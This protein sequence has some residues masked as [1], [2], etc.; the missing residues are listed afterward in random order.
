M[1]KIKIFI[2]VIIFSIS[3]YSQSS[4][5]TS[6]KIVKFW[7][8]NGIS[9][10]E[11]VIKNLDKLCNDNKLSKMGVFDLFDNYIDFNKLNN[12]LKPDENG[13]Y[14]NYTAVILGFTT[15]KA[16]ELSFFSSA[17]L[18][19]S[20][21]SDMAAL[22]ILFDILKGNDQKFVNNQIEFYT[23]YVTEGIMDPYSDPDLLDRGYLRASTRSKLFGSWVLPNTELTPDTVKKIVMNSYNRIHGTENDFDYSQQN[24]AVESY[25]QFEKNA[26]SI[27]GYINGYYTDVVLVNVN[28]YHKALTFYNNGVDTLKNMKL[29]K[30][31]DQVISIGTIKPKE[32]RIITSG[33]IQDIDASSFDKI[34][35]DLFGFT[36]SLDY[37]QEIK[38]FGSTVTLKTDITDTHPG[39]APEQVKFQILVNTDNI[40]D[41]P[42]EITIDYG[43]K[44]IETIQTSTHDGLKNISIP[45]TYKQKGIFFPS[46]TVKN[47]NIANVTSTHFDY[48]EVDNPIKIKYPLSINSNYYAGVNSVWNS[49][50][51]SSIESDFV[52]HWDFEYNN[53]NFIRDKDS[54]IANWKFTP[55]AS[56]FTNNRVVESTVAL[57]ASVNIDNTIYSDTLF[58]TVN[59]FNPI[60]P[61][62]NLLPSTKN[63]TID[64]ASIPYQVSLD[65]SASISKTGK[66]LNYRWYINKADSGSTQ[67]VN[68]KILK[69]GKHLIYLYISDGTYNSEIRDS[70]NV[71]YNVKFNSDFSIN[72][73]EYF[74]DNDPGV[75]KGYS[76]PVTYQNSVIFANS[77]ISCRNL[78]T[79]LH[80][81]YF[82]VK[83]NSGRWSIPQS[84]IVI[85]QAFNPSATQV[86]DAE[87]FFD[88]DPG[89]GNG[90]KMNVPT[91]NNI[92]TSTLCNLQNIT[93][94]LHRI[95]FRAKDNLGNWSI[96]QSQIV[97]VQHTTTI[98]KKVV[99]AE[100]FFDQDP[101]YGN[102]IK[103]PIQ[104][105]DSISIS[106]IE[107]IQNISVGL[108]RM[109]FRVKNSSGNWGIPQ[110]QIVIIQNASNSNSLSKIN[111]A[112]YFFDND[113]GLGLATKFNITSSDDVL[114][115][116]TLNLENL[117]IGIHTLSVRVRD[118]SG[119]WSI[120]VAAQFE[121]EK[122]LYTNLV[123]D[124]LNQ[125]NKYTI[126]GGRGRFTVVTPNNDLVRVYQLKVYSL[127]GTLI[128]DNNI[129][130]SHSFNFNKGIY[131]VEIIDKSQREKTTGKILVY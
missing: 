35:F 53:N 20:K 89:Y 99:D 123:T 114:I 40:N 82:R 3:V 84:Q 80:R 1:T 122:G 103:M 55:A 74:F 110:S 90:L 120:P 106:T 124:K 41:E 11:K 33:E 6:D 66:P 76:I 47:K 9:V 83:D 21:A 22:K 12:D 42:F 54:I 93:T 73:I 86:T 23:Q 4:G 85:V 69:S 118:E 60:V 119:K 14:P 45:H 129:V 72:Q 101:G 10:S 61:K 5:S 56:K 104:S 62:L 125:G 50:S 51:V 88:Q 75:G 34:Q 38:P 98:S 16:S 57:V 108:H 36:I 68:Y 127:N 24:L 112:E 115:N 26:E 63:L 15:K 8:D 52:S 46:I 116:E 39:I 27:E 78:S 87:Y 30:N 70:I 91:G 113:P 19:V 109:Y 81:I 48:I 49:E 105:G 117:S 107:N 121:V 79:G 43:D 59:V 94:G 96:P 111:Y 18:A 31:T 97:I 17:S 13:V 130:G 65:A 44:T 95:Y 37:Q 28:G 32:T 64:I 71:D 128:F 100:Y 7:Q 92:S 58:Q 126:Y 67:K 131:T 29:I 25:K 77:N 102:A 2:A